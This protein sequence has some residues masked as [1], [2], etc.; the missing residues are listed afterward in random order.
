MKRSLSGSSSMRQRKGD[1]NGI[2]HRNGGGYRRDRFG[3]CRAVRIPSPTLRRRTLNRAYDFGIRHFDVAP[4]YGLGIAEREL[5]VLARR[6]RESMTI[7]TKFGIGM[8]SIGRMAGVVQA[9]IRSLLRSS[10]SIWSGRSVVRFLHNLRLC[11]RA[12][13][14]GCPFQ[15]KASESRSRG[16]ELRAF[17]P[18]TSTCSCFTNRPSSLVSWHRTLSRSWRAKGSAARLDLGRGR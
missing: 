16:L 5:G 17:R 9:P 10:H 6:G 14:P 1:E 4:M 15:R 18:T 8:T 3:L 7:A 11:G 12:A 13:L 2:A